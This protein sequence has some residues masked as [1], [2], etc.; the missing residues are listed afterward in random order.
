MRVCMHVT[1]C[2]NVGKAAYYTEGPYKKCFECI[3]YTADCVI[4]IIGTNAFFLSFEVLFSFFLSRLVFFIVRPAI[5]KKANILMT[6]RAEGICV[7]RMDMPNLIKLCGVGG[8]GGT[9]C[10]QTQSKSYR[11]FLNV[12]LLCIRSKLRQ[13]LTLL[14]SVFVIEILQSKNLFKQMRTRL[15]KMKVLASNFVPVVVHN[16][17]LCA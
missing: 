10:L 9:G 12:L 2:H 14:F 15:I 6:Q 8:R 4:R 1:A 5:I 7:E 11:T 16:A 13:A 3:W 17:V